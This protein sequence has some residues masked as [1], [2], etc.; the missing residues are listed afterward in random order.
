MLLLFIVL[1]IL[2]TA[3]SLYYLRDIDSLNSLL[4]L[5]KMKT[6]VLI[7][8]FTTMLNFVG[9]SPEIGTDC[10]DCGQTCL[11]RYPRGGDFYCSRL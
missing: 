9:G 10:E 4:Y 3:T 1:S 5:M 11:D 8:M 7:T 6:F 2:R